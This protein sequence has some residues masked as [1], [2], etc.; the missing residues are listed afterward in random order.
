MTGAPDL[1]DNSTMK[2]YTRDE[3]LGLMA[4]VMKKNDWSEREFC[5]NAGI[6]YQ[7]SQ[8]W[9][10]PRAPKINYEDAMRIIIAA[11]L[12][13]NQDSK[14]SSIRQLSEEVRELKD[15][16]SEVLSENMLLRNKR[17]TS[18]KSNV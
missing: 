4:E 5:L 15:T 7:H 9:K 18:K 14:S 8:D 6:R 11:N 16:V 13:E 17:G 3:L 12:P 2:I 1:V 10:R